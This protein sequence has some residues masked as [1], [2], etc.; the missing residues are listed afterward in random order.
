MLSVK[1]ETIRSGEFSRGY[2]C[3]G[4]KITGADR[5]PPARETC[6]KFA[7]CRAWPPSGI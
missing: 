1:S 2:H 7:L 6:P 3:H 5:Q 4:W